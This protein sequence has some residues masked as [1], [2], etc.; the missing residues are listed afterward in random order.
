MHIISRADH[1][2]VLQEF[3]FVSKH[4]VYHRAVHMYKVKAHNLHKNKVGGPANCS[5]C[6]RTNQVSVMQG[7]RLGTRW[8][9]VINRLKHET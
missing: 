9:L 1:I 3:S 5:Y 4:Q 8:Y 7:Q 6:L 2:S